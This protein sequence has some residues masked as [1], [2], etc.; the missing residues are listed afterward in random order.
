MN[1][2]KRQPRRQVFKASTPPAE[3]PATMMS[4][5]G[6]V[7]SVSQTMLA[8][9]FGGLKSSRNLRGVKPLKLWR[10]RFDDPAVRNNAVALT[11]LDQ[12]LLICDRT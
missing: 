2:G 12:V 4:C 7:Q 6:I 9:C 11:V 5:L 3:A 10:Q 1:E 8:I